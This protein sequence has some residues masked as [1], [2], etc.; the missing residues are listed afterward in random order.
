MSNVNPE[1]GPFANCGGSTQTIPLLVASPAINSGDTSVCSTSP[2]NGQD[3]RS[4]ARRISYCDIGAFEAQPYSIAVTSG[5]NQSTLVNCAF[6]TPLQVHVVDVNTNGLGGVGTTFTPP[7][8][9]ASAVLSSTFGTTNASGNSRV[10]ATANN[11]VGGPYGILVSSGVLPPA[12][13]YLTNIGVIRNL[14]LPL[15]RR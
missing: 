12:T 14:F 11:V 3:Q 2:V 9:G 15:I 8:G 13:I 6:P 7:L 10:N 1:L 4:L 5:S